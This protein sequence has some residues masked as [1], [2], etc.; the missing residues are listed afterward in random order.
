MNGKYIFFVH[1]NNLKIL[2]SAYLLFLSKF[3][4]DNIEFVQSLVCT[5]G[6]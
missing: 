5:S 4:L 3:D 2:K 1:A 6:I